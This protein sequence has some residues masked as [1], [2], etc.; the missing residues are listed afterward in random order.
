MCRTK[1]NT[2]PRK[3]LINCQL[4]CWKYFTFYEISQFFR[5]RRVEN[6]WMLMVTTITVV[7]GNINNLSIIIGSGTIITSSSFVPILTSIAMSLL[8]L[9][10]LQSLFFGNY[11]PVFR[12]LGLQGKQVT[13]GSRDQHLVFP[14]VFLTFSLCWSFFDLLVSL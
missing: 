7:I 9:F 1:I 11:N 12:K 8:F 2:Y 10:S 3:F 5:C 13:W 4:H 14:V 6:S